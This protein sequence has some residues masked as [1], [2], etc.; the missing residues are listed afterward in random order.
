[1]KRIDNI[2]TAWIMMMLLT[3]STYA[4]GEQAYS[5]VTVVL[6]LLLT[7][8]IKS[9]LLIRDFMELK[10]VSLLWQVIMYGWLGTVCL[11]IAIT[12]MMSV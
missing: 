7:A 1:M 9:S 4:I 12:Y 8:A 6:L 10:G 3:L 11:A 2:H 5:G